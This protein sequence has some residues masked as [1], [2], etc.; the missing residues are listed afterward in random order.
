VIALVDDIVVRA[1][2]HANRVK[3]LISSMFNFRHRRDCSS[4]IPPT[5]YQSDTG[6]IARPL[7][8]PMMRSVV[9]GWPSNGTFEGQSSI[10]ACTSDCGPSFGAARDAWTELDLDSGWWTLPA[11]RTKAGKAHRIPL[12]PT[13]LGLLRALQVIAIRVRI[14]RPL[15][16]TVVN[17]QKWNERLVK[18]AAR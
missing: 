7:S 18:R 10:S 4:K 14:Q 1:P 2:V 9:Y 13:A 12:S 15:R 3:A 16:Q 8:M 5:R 11:D 17:P 6:A